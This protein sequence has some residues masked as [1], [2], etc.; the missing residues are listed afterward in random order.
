MEFNKVLAG[1]F[2]YVGLHRRAL[3]KALFIPFLV[4]LLIEFL[5]QLDLHFVLNWALVVPV[6]VVQSI[7]AIT[8]HRILLLGPDSVPTF[9]IISW[10]KRETYFV[11]HVI[12]L[13]LLFTAITFLIFVSFTGGIIASLV[14][15]C[16]MGRLCL[17]FPGI[18]IDRGM[19]FRHSWEMSA[20]HNL[21]MFLVVIVFPF[22]LY[23]PVALLARLPYTFLLTGVLWTALIV[24]QIAALS[25]AY[26]L[27]ASKIDVKHNEVET[28]PYP[29]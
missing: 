19:T 8:T 13:W 2:Y 25:M 1:A 26:R 23:I 14:F 29:T 3:A 5:T 27:L 15:I 4:Y 17:V 20:N 22:L 21:L 18:S 24:L 9:G 16:I 11:V 12:G 7:L 6:I 10:S 28:D